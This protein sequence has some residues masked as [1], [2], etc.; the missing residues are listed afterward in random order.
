MLFEAGAVLTLFT[1]MSSGVAGVYTQKYLQQ[2]FGSVWEGNIVLSTIGLVFS[3]MY[4]AVKA[5]EDMLHPFEGWTPLVVLVACSQ[6]GYGLLV[7]ASI[8][9]NSSLLKSVTTTVS[10]FISLALDALLFEEAISAGTALGA[11]V[12]VFS[13]LG[14]MRHPASAPSPSALQQAGYTSVA[15]DDT[16]NISATEGSNSSSKQS[17]A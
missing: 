12:L 9:Y 4:F 7:A 13:S 1:S 17:T 5:P 2:H 15:T 16:E 14:Y 10:V 8:T 11:A 3:L 6:A